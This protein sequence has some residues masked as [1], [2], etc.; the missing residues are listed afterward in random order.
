MKLKK[1]IAVSLLPLNVLLLFFLCFS[2]KI[3]VPAWLQV[4]G[5]M[6]PLLLHFP[7]VLILLY[8]G[9]VLLAAREIKSAPWYT[10]IAEG[11]LIAASFTA[12]ITALTGFL[13]SKEQGY[14]EGTVDWHKWLGAALSFGLFALYTV[15]EKIRSPFLFNTS[16]LV[17]IGV[18]LLAA[19]LG[20]TITHGENFVLA[21]VT[22]DK[23]KELPPLEEA[24]VYAHLIEP[25]LEAKCMNCHNSS[26]SKGEL[27]MTTKESLL[28]GGKNGKLWDTT[29]AEGL[30]LQRIHLPEE[31][32]KHMPPIGKPQL[33]P[34]EMKLLEIWIRGGAVFDKRVIELPDGD[35]LKTL[36]ATML[37]TAEEE[38]YDFEA[39][40]DRQVQQLSNNNRVITPLAIGS[41]ALAVSF[42]NRAFYHAKELEALRPLE[43]QIVSLNLDN[44]PVK[45][46]DL[47][48]IARFKNLRKLN[49]NF[50][51]ITGNT[52]AG[53]KKL[54]QLKSLSLSG[55]PVKAEQLKSL[56]S[57][58]NLKTVYVWNTAITDQQA[59]QL[60]QAHAAI[61]YHT[62]FK[63]T[64]TLKISPPVIENEEQVITKPVPLK[65]KHYIRGAEI[66]YTLDGKDP[67]SL[68]SPVY[69]QELLLQ[70]TGVVK[71]K[72]F[73]PGWIGSEVVQQHFYRSTWKADSA[74]LLPDP[75]PK[76]KASGGNTLIDLV[77]SNPDY[78]NGKWIGFHGQQVTATMLFNNPAH[79]SSITISMIKS[80]NEHI[81]PPA[82]IQVWGGRDKDHLSLLQTIHPPPPANDDRARENV[83]FDSRFAVQEIGCIKLVL[84]PI[85]N[86]FPW[87]K[88]KNAKSWLF[89][90]EV[91][92]N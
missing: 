30:L 70:E 47:A 21:P 29:Q 60:R 19:H 1:A 58:P 82:S 8:A 14:E 49:L 25:I 32:K 26:K 79:V 51:A 78:G 77:K 39:P 50:T 48:I 42:Y 54:Q 35:T 65:L 57:L 3:V 84:K 91:F 13:L 63:D 75:D 73:K 11:L 55:T 89:I 81:F 31:A 86:V 23:Q 37:K 83:T 38:T 52:L 40:E 2:S 72:A 22:P 9:W 53:L 10:N 17:I 56:Q 44:M 45:D 7:I 71:A 61:Y 15:R 5:R 20:A 46:E 43:T 6:H 88:D 64:V 85:P 28:K 68:S 62:G 80:V 16:I 4:S 33:T 74:I 12:A 67:D 59:S 41:P 66:R 24:V 92:I 18:L 36:A 76:Y 90:D 34:F 27:I 87:L 69:N